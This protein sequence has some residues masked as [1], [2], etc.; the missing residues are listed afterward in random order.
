MLN[1]FDFNNEDLSFLIDQVGKSVKV[2]NVEK[3]ILITGK[4]IGEFEERYIHSTEM[5]KRGAMIEWN[6]NKYLVTSETLEKRGGKYKAVI[7]SCNAQIEFEK[8]NKVFIGNDPRTGQ[9]IYKDEYIGTEY[10]NAIV[11]KKSLSIATGEAINTVDNEFILKVQDNSINR[12]N[13][14]LNAT[15]KMYNQTWKVD[16]HDYTKKG[17]LEVSITSEIN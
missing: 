8:Y 14:A 16:N 15:F 13:F 17:I 9:P 1:L 2:N 3:V 7:R 5:I 6:N 10:V 4:S 12:T 11:D